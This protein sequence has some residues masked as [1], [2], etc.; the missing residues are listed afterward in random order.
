[1]FISFGLINKKWILFLL[2]P[3]SVVAF[4]LLED[5]LKDKNLFLS[6]FVKIIARLSCIIPYFC[7]SKSLSNEHEVKHSKEKVII[8]S[9]INDNNDSIHSNNSNNSKLSNNYNQTMGTQYLLSENKKR[10]EKKKRK[11]GKLYFYLILSGLID[12]LALAIRY[13]VFRINYIEELSEGTSELS[14]FFRVIYFVVLPFFLIK[15]KIH[16]HQV[17]S[18]IFILI[19][20]IIG[21]SLHCLYNLDKKYLKQILLVFISELVYCLR[22]VVG[23]AYLLNSE[24]NIYTLLF[25]NGI[26]DLMLLAA[27]IISLSLLFDCKTDLDTLYDIDK[28]CD[29]N[30]IKSI[31]DIIYFKLSE[32]CLT[33]LLTFA[34]ISG[35]I[36]I[37]LLIYY[38]SVTHYAAIFTIPSFILFLIYTN[39][40]KV[41]YIFLFVILILMTLIYN[42]IIILNFCGLE[43]ETKKEIIK[44]SAD[45]SSENKSNYDPN[46]LGDDVISENMEN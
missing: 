2:V 33:I 16:R 14:S 7:I 26:I 20:I 25:I 11:S 44:R 21:L 1:M 19:V 37:W 17:F 23:I 22:Y 30:R 34:D 10:I 13:L 18:I 45:D 29:G 39:P 41:Y 24:G 9:E 4:Y 36:C 27:L 8:I 31:I 38:F 28:F 3:L 5:K 40:I 15:S 12:F 32:I 6:F 35:L 46:D 42:E 43:K